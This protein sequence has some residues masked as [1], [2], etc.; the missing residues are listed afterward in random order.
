MRTD[1]AHRLRQFQPHRP[2]LYQKIQ[3]IIARHLRHHA[4]TGQQRRRGNRVPVPIFQPYRQSVLAGRQPS[5]GWP[6]R[7]DRHERAGRDPSVRPRAAQQLVA[8]NS[9]GICPGRHGHDHS[10][11]Q[12]C[13]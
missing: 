13:L 12:L 8:G 4:H 10:V 11:Q 6:H 3:S 7:P 5:A 2:V 9:P 1:A